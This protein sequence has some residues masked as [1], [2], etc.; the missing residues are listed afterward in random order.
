MTG[1]AKSVITRTLLEEGS[2]IGVKLIKHLPVS[3]ATA[4][5][6]Q[7]VL[8]RNNQPITVV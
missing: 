2:A 8:L 1:I 4:L 3:L 5:N 7:T 6:S